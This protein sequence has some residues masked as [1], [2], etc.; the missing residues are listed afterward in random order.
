MCFFGNLG[1]SPAS[2]SL[3]TTLQS[4]WPIGQVNQARG[5]GRERERRQRGHVR[6]DG[7]AAAIAIVR[8]WLS[9]S[10]ISLALVERE[11]GGGEEGGGWVCID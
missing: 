6:G 7:V 4:G 10:G 3:L 8:V 11:K 9:S 2:S 5:K 1:L